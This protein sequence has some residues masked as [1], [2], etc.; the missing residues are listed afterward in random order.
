MTNVE[1]KSTLKAKGVSQREVV[2][3][4]IDAG[5]YT[6]DE[7]QSLKVRINMALSGKRNSEIYVDL[8]NQVEFIISE[9][10]EE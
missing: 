5:F 3:R 2:S 7:R 9:S 6:E 8:L 1:L 10:Q 4:L